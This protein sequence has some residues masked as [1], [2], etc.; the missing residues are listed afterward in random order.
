MAKQVTYTDGQIRYRR[1]KGVQGAWK[2][3]RELVRQGRGTRN[4]S[5]KEQKEIIKAGKA[6]GYQGHHMKS[7]KDYP[8]HADNP[9]N[10]QFLSARKGNNEHL[11]AHKGNYKNASSGRYNVNTGKIR[12][13]GEGEPKTPRSQKLDSRAIDM[14][15]YQKYAT[16]KSEASPA[17]RYAKAE[18]TPAA[19]QKGAS[20]YAAKAKGDQP[21]YS[22]SYV[23]QG[24]AKRQTS[25]GQTS[26]GKG[27][28]P[29][30]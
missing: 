28:S 5:V 15:G 1:S 12:Q 18:K 14:K 23:K 19:R 20:P 13:M 17:Q 9:N 25:G 8:Q 24:S 2:R 29:K 7:V 3:E 16:A 30:R 11:A 4:W 21:T 26:S 6:Q 27:A 22:R 10:V